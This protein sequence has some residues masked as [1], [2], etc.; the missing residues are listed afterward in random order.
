ME[1]VV[2]AGLDY[3]TSMYSITC[4]TILFLTILGADYSKNKKCYKEVK[5]T[6]SK[7]LILY[8]I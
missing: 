3:F 6:T 8:D 2:K 4:F 5:I 1:S 7:Y